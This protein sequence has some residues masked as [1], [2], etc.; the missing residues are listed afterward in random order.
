MARHGFSRCSSKARPFPNHVLR[1]GR[2]EIRLSEIT[3]SQLKE[4]FS[5]VS[6]TD[7]IRGDLRL[8]MAIGSL[9]GPGSLSRLQ[10][11]DSTHNR[12]SS[13]LSGLLHGF[14]A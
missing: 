1:V 3:Y 4:I 6:V 13:R 7:A 8:L 12:E 11:A 10:F 2:Q 14:R 5:K 9:W